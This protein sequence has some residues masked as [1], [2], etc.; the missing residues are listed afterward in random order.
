MD[1][2]TKPAPSGASVRIIILGAGR[3]G[4]SLAIALAEEKDHAIT[5]VDANKKRL[6][7]FE[8]RG[9][10]STLCGN[11]AHPDIL[12]NADIENA[13]M[14]VALTENDEVNIAACH[15][16][17]RLYRTP[18]CIARVRATEHLT[19]K[20]DVITDALRINLLISPEQRAAHDI[21]LL[22]HRPGVL[23]VLDFAD[24]CAQMAA[25]R[26]EPGAP[27]A[28]RRLRELYASLPDTPLRI[29][30][31]YRHR[32]RG[33]LEA[34]PPDDDLR[35]QARDEVFAFAARGRLDAVIKQLRTQV[36][37]VRHVLIAGGSHIGYSLAKALEPRCQVKLVEQD[38]A[39]ARYL[40]ENLQDR[41]LVLC[42]NAADESLLHDENLEDMD[43]F[44]ALTD[45]D[46]TNIVTAMQAKRLGVA[47]TIAMINRA[48]YAGLVENAADR[49][50]DIVVS[51]QQAALSELLV[52]IRRGAVL[53][54]HS[55]RSGSAEA[56]EFMANPSSLAVG[57][58]VGALE[59]P[60]S[61]AVGALVRGDALLRHNPSTVIEHGD[62]VIL[63][64]SRKRDVHA[65]EQLFQVGYS[66]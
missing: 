52:H 25:V 53:T 31:V 34:Q 50:I 11:G 9:D 26:V 3:I 16:A 20:R 18:K 42:G 56:L 49:M 4:G 54:G 35:L 40:S 47:T 66:F 62:R 32:D 41:T 15:I 28:G 29:A 10:L 33:G 22:L 2:P 12:E 7:R 65:V 1:A 55:L 24:G 60:A 46:E 63:F 45:H 44:C 39:R 23:Q 58:S 21:E 6:T 51:P 5:L 61:T 37:P 27:A 64:C 43:A 19:L 17:K 57:Q 48:S 14:L 59:L 30:A 36:R 13:D 8:K 38:E